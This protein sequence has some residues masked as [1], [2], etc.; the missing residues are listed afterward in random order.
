MDVNMPKMDGF[1]AMRQIKTD[2]DLANILIIIVSGTQVDTDSQSHGLETGADGYITR[3]ISN[4]ELLARVRAMLRIKQAEDEI[5][6][7][8]R[9][10]E[11]RVETRT[12]ELQQAQEKLLRQ[13]KLAIL[14]QLAGSVGHELR[15]PLG[16]IDNAVYFLR[17]IQPDAAPQIHKYL[18]IIEKEIHIAEKIITDLLDFARVQSAERQAVKVP[19]LAASVLQ[20]YPLPEG[21]ALHLD[22][23]ANLPLAFA[24]PQHIEQ[25]IG[26]LVLNALQAMKA[27]GRLTIE[28]SAST[29]EIFI[30]V[31]DTGEGIAPENMA[32]LFE[33]LFTTRPKGIGLGLA[34]CK[35][36]AEANG[37]RVAVESELGVGSTFTLIV[38]VYPGS[39][40]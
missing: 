32:R 24:D 5:R 36:L 21:V 26:N 19:D 9:E 15:N 14:G 33:P 34:V 13:E 20:R 27:G 39:E 16:V 25:V 37:G 30:R 10:L 1:E 29:E 12:R 6:Q 11:Q 17:A 35:K 7:W 40:E 22:F 8:N 4:R 23:P 3:P 28:A 2:P 38:P 31:A 18:G